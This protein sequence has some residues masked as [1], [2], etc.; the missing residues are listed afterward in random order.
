MLNMRTRNSGS[1]AAQGFSLIE[2]M[3]SVTIGMIV[4]AGA[5]TLIVAIDQSNSE[6]IQATRLTQELRALAG[7]I[8]DDIKRTRRL[9]D[10]V[11]MVGQGNAK[12]CP[13]APTTPNQPCYKIKTHTISTNST[14]IPSCLT[15]GY[16]GTLSDKSIFN[17]RAVRKE[18][19]NLVIDEYT[20]DPNSVS[21]GTALPLDSDVSDPCPL[22]VSGVTAYPLNASQIGITSFCV[23][24]ST[25]AG[26][27]YF[28]STTSSCALNS[29]TPPTNEIDIC[30]A[31]QL[32]AGDKYMK[33]ITH[34]FV[35]PIF[36][37]S[38]AAGS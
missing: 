10:P 31:G 14:T 21:A 22:T 12:T 17:Y 11:A 30:I 13:T 2:L 33:T 38:N 32:T 5:V 25:D 28:D 3:I 20:F 6:T 27:C 29:A 7:V 9:D 35:Q 24:Q 18:G 15:Y 19:S 36:V 1:F 8:A 26:T 37:R 34:G 23:S 4:A 16:T